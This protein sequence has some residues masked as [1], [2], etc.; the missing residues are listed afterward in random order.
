MIR[1][2]LG[3]QAILTAVLLTIG[4]GLFCPPAVAEAP[5]WSESFEQGR[6]YFDSGNYGRAYD[7]FLEAFK[8]DPGNLEIDFYLGRAAFEISDYETALMAFER[9]LIAQPAAMRVKLEM[10]RTYYRLGLRANARQY[11]EEVL[12]SN[13]PAAV[14]RNIEVFLTDIKM[15]EKRH[16]FSGQISTGLDWDDNVWVAPADE[17]VDTAVGD[18]VLQGKGAKPEEDWIFNTTGILNYSYQPPESPYAWASTGAVYQALYREESELDTLFLA[19]NT[20]PEFRSDRYL[21]G[22]HGL[23]N[24]LEIDWERYLRTAGVEMIFS[25]LFGPQVLLNITPKFEDKKFYQIEQRDSKNFNLTVGSV[26]LWGANRIGA[27]AAGEVENAEDD[28]YSY[29]QIGGLIN[30]ERQLPY[31]L[32]VFGYYEYRYKA[33][34][35]NQAFFDKKRKDHLHYAGAGLSKTLWRSSDFRQNLSLRFN[36][37]YTHSDSNIDLYAYDKNVASA[38]LTYSF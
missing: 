37:R 12:A 36:Y 38:S 1:I 30:W 22:L 11:F 18:V 20:G 7:L 34:E 27:A 13:P 14:R 33:Y 19:L 35:D 29:R 6:L 17:V 15:A 5:A 28:I 3:I 2:H 8:A 10:A 25:M 23:V 26:I 24:H 32:T 4:L 16:F 31:E 9:I 21:L